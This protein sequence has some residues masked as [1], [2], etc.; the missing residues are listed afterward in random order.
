[1]IVLEEPYKCDAIKPVNGIPSTPLDKKISQHRYKPT[2][3]PYIFDF[4]QTDH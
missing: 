4:I 1:M 3:K 2:K